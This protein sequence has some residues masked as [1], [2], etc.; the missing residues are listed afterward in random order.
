M[1]LTRKKGKVLNRG[2]R[3][4]STAH[5]FVIDELRGDSLSNF[6]TEKARLRSDWYLIILC[7]VCIAGYGWSVDRKMVYPSFVLCLFNL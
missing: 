3:L 1:E 5:N 2:Y 7:A 6:P 4:T